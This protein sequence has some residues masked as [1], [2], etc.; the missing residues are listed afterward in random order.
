M[1]LSA[2][3]LALA[4]A[5]VHAAWN[6]LLG[7]SEDTQAATAVAVIAGVV[8]F[9]PFALVHWRLDAEALPYVGASAVLEL[10]YLA[11]L[12]TAYSLADVGF[13]YPIARGSAPVLVLAIGAVA[14]GAGVS[15]LSVGGVLLVSAGIVLV[16][17]LTDPG[18]PR[19]LALALAVGASIAAFTLVDK[20]GVAHASPLS[21][22]QLVFDLTALG[23]VLGALRVRGANA[24]RT[25]AGW[26]PALAGV[27]FFGSY[28]LALAALQ[29]APA[30]SVAA[31]RETSVVM[32]AAW[33]A[34]S[35]REH[36]TPVR[37]A[38]ASAVAAGIACVALG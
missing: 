2:L 13:V 21:Y 18:R 28:T 38:G 29:L 17:G 1:A 8:V 22:L 34:L 32:A 35:G 26:R 23:Y 3:L 36:M 10:I 7:D 4:A 20:R 15:P 14:L 24:I 31:V 27:G 11:L 16:R 5:V 25:A 37:F 9:T 6:V 33:L 19:D 30:A 12:A